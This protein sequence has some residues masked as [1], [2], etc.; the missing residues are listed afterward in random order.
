MKNWL[1]EKDPDAG[2]D[3]RQKEKGVEEDKMV[4]QHHRLN[5]HEFEQTP[6]DSGGQRSLACYTSWVTKRQTQL[7]NWTTS[8]KVSN[9]HSEGV[10]LYSGIKTFEWV[11]ITSR[12]QARDLR[13]LY[14][15]LDSM[16]AVS[17]SIPTPESPNLV[18]NKPLPQWDTISWG[19]LEF[20]KIILLIFH[21][22]QGRNSL[23]NK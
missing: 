16:A 5:G 12:I 2:K 11:P 22:I 3:W 9:S 14:K 7:G 18:N 13:L 23:R 17:L 21:G 1:I 4:R 15:D 6:G 10:L 19:L 8:C 20:W